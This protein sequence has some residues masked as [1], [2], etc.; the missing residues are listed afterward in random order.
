M[1]GY[2]GVVVTVLMMIGGVVIGVGYDFQL[3]GTGMFVLG[4]LMFA[5]SLDQIDIYQRE[6]KLDK[7]MEDIIK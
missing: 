2:I 7:K 4:F 3:A 5:A 1:T 6:K